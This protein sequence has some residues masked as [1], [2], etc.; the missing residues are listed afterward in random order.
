MKRKIPNGLFGVV[1]GNQQIVRVAGSLT[2]II[3][4]EVWAIKWGFSPLRGCT[5]GSWWLFDGNG[6]MA[7]EH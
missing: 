3:L 6:P 1:V 4:I 7:S 2:L 5:D